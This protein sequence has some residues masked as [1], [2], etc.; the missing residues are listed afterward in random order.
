MTLVIF[1]SDV[2]CPPN[3]HYRTCGSACPP[4]CESNSTIC[5]K[6]CAHGCFCNPGFTKSPVGCIR[7]YQCGCTDSGGN[8]YSLNSTFWTPD[9]CG[10]LCECGPAAGEFHCRPAQCP[11]GMVCKQLHHKRMCEPEK[12]LNCTI[13]TGLHFK[14]FDGN[15]YNFRDSCAYSLVQT[16]SNLTELTSFNITISNANCHKR[17]FLGFTLTLSIYGLEVVVSKDDPGKVMVS[18][19]TTFLINQ[20]LGV[21]DSNELCFFLSSV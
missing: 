10:Q 13:V 6:A 17:L 1:I 21:C 3:S 16:K 15:H 11:Q 4:S 8:Y 18:T 20:R 7:P 9:N 19:L 5:T 2:H 14:T 12:P